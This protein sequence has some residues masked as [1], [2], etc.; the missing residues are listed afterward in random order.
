MDAVSNDICRI[1]W[2]TGDP[3]VN[4]ASVEVGFELSTSVLRR[5]ADAGCVGI[6]N[7]VG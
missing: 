7:A 5:E 1:A 3:S 2:R 4:Q 6:V